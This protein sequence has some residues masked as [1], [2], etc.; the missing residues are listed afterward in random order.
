M[1]DKVFIKAQAKINL[2]LHIINKRDD[3]FYNIR[4][5]VTFLDLYDEVSIEISNTQSLTYSGPFKPHLNFFEND[6]IIKTLNLL[7]LKKNIKLKLHIK[8]N[9][10]TQS[11]LGSASTNAAALIKGLIKLGI[12]DKKNNKFLS[13]L[14]ADVP[15]CFYG[16]DCLI[17][18]IGNDNLHSN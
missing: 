7:K 5:G 18:G 10:P 11:G 16:D 13:I 4:S 1:L 12:V 17:T 8:K 14:G 15:A 6:I 2:F 9:I 3:G